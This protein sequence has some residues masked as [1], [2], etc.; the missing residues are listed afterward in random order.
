MSN[1]LLEVTRTKKITVGHQTA[2]SI[3]C[4]MFYAEFLRDKKTESL[5]S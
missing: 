4:H 2:I 5:T 3:E 1:N